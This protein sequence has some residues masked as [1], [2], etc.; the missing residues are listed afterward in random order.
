[1]ELKYWARLEFDK[2]F[3]GERY[4]ATKFKFKHLNLERTIYIH[5]FY[6]EIKTIAIHLEYGC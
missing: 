3:H 1:M 5:N 6:K 2:Y 4:P